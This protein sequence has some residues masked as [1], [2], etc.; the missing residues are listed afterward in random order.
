MTRFGKEE[1][2]EECGVSVQFRLFS[3]ET[4]DGNT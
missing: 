3:D 2:V 1:E 4:M